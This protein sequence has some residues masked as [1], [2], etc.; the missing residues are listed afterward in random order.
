MTND[1]FIGVFLMG[2]G[3]A[4]IA[5]LEFQLRFIG[6]MGDQF[7][8]PLRSMRSSSGLFDLWTDRHGSLCKRVNRRRS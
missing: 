2:L 8:T 1:A 6:D 7:A 5:I 4:A 3:S